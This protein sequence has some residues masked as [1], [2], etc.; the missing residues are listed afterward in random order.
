MSL[1]VH[2]KTQKEV[3]RYWAKLSKGGKLLRCG[4]L[5][6]RYGLTWQIIPIILL[7]FLGDED[8]VKAGRAMQAM[9]KMRK[10]DIKTLKRARAGR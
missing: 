4:W 8:P 3:D 6:D 2:C 1:F 5:T 7:D 9:L 10:I